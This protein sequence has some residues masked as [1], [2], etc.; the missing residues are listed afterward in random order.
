MLAICVP[1]FQSLIA[2]ARILTAIRDQNSFIYGWN[3]GHD[4][5]RCTTP[6]RLWS[7]EA[8]NECL[9]PAR[10]QRLQC[11]EQLPRLDELRPRSG[12]APHLE[13][14][15]QE[16]AWGLLGLYRRSS[17]WWIENNAALTLSWAEILLMSLAICWRF[18]FLVNTTAGARLSS[19]F[20]KALWLVPVISRRC[21]L[22]R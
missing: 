20:V 6:K 16:I 13:R 19:S 2:F 8:W 3:E 15:I 9:P 12:R 18:H 1:I 11:R 7:S 14:S 17:F 21:C 4:R 10:C 5:I 22:C